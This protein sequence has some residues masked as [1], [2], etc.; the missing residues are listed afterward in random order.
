MR[1]FLCKH[2]LLSES[3]NFFSEICMESHD[4]ANTNTAFVTILLIDSSFEIIV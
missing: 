3:H 2:T 1:I 4:F